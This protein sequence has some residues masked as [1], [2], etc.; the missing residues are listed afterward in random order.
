MQFNIKS[1]SLEHLWIFQ[2]FRVLLF[3]IRCS[4]FVVFISLLTPSKRNQF[5]TYFFT[6]ILKSAKKAAR[7]S[8]SINNQC[9]IWRRNVS[10][11]FTVFLSY[12]K[13]LNYK[14]KK[15]KPKKHGWV[16]HSINQFSLKIVNVTYLS[17]KIW[18]VY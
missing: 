3:C 9:V 15:L 2:K 1:L 4:F 10:K 6:D 16:E 7:T 11:S 12:P 13:K 14:W 18:T 8:F 5:Q 17:R